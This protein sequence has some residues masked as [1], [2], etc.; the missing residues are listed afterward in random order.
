MTRQHEL[1]KQRCTRCGDGTAEVW[2]GAGATLRTYN[3]TKNAATS[4]LGTNA[5]RLLP[6]CTALRPLTARSDATAAMLLPCPFA[7]D[8]A[9][10][11]IVLA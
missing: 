2:G 5:A 1:D 4:Q 10:A 6:L 8:S 3:T 9:R 11:T 7:L